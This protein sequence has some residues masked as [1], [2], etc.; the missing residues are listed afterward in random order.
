MIFWSESRHTVITITSSV[1]ASVISRFSLEFTLVRSTSRC[2]GRVVLLRK[3]LRSFVTRGALL[4]PFAWCRSST[5]T[6][7]TFCTIS[8][9]LVAISGMRCAYSCITGSSKSLGS[10]WLVLWWVCWVWTRC[11]R[12]SSINPSSTVKLIAA[13]CCMI[14]VLC[15][16]IIFFSSQLWPILID[17][18]VSF[19]KILRSCTTKVFLLSSNS[20][21]YLRSDLGRIKLKHL[22]VLSYYVDISLE[23]LK[24]IQRA[25][26]P[27]VSYLL[28]FM[29]FWH[30]IGLSFNLVCEGSEP[31]SIEAD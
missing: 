13:N 3:W 12:W 11:R 4:N 10:R 26:L 15:W 7:H 24:S 22:K 25:S 9:V 30:D 20:I 17:I 14:C 5:V 23:S 27:A 19:S 18:M 28:S 31:L 16:H 1:W 6:R 8:K 21:L 2:R 29:Y